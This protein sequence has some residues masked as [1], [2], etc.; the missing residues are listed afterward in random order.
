MRGREREIEWE[1][2]RG[3]ERR[4]R[5][6]VE[7]STEKRKEKDEHGERKGRRKGEKD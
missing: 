4:E 1:A 2:R 5:V 6:D 3:L 7:R